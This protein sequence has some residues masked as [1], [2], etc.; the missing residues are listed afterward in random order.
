MDRFP[1]VCTQVA[2]ILLA[3]LFFAASLDASGHTIHIGRLALGFGLDSSTKELSQALTPKVEAVRTK[4]SESRHALHTLN[5][6]GSVPAHPVQEVNDLV[7]RTGTDLDEAIEQVGAPELAGLRA[8]SADKLRSIQEQLKALP[9]QTA[10]AFPGFSNPRAIALVA[11]LKSR[12]LPAKAGSAAPKT[13]TKTVPADVSDR[14]LDKLGDVV[15]R[16]FFLASHDD[17]EVKLW[18]GSTPAQKVDFRFWTQGQIKGS[19]PEPVTIR[20]N[21]KKEHILRGLYSYL[22]TL[23]QKSGSHLIAYPSQAGAPAG[24]LASEQLDLVTGSN[25]FCCHFDDGYCQHVADEKECH[26]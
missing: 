1:A 14:L 2:S 26:S 13:M 9:V 5:G 3:N 15:D 20:T 4:L 16:I 19:A 8:W 23:P 10:V 21:G 25:F 7:T 17:L 18:V 22:A 11:N 6:P 12:P 24:G